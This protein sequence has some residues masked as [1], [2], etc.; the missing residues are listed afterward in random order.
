[1]KTATFVKK[2]ETGDHAW[3]GRARLFRLSH[4]VTYVADW[5]ESGPVRKRTRWVIVSA[6]VTPTGKPETIVFASDRDG[7]PKP[8]VKDSQTYGIVDDREALSRIGFWEDNGLCPQ[9]D[10]DGYRLDIVGAKD[11]WV[12]CECGA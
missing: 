1:M 5:T 7:T 10:G 4:R 9:C 8:A 2:L 12:R 3:R 6:C 11:V